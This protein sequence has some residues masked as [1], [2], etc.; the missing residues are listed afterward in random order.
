MALKEVNLDKQ[1]PEIPEKIMF[2][3]RRKKNLKKLKAT[4]ASLTAKMEP[5][6][7]RE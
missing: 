5:F 3:W 7:D 4:A 6:K 2:R 1:K